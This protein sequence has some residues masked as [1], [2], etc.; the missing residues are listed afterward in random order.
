MVRILRIRFLFFLLFLGL[1]S[2]ERLID[3]IVSCYAIYKAPRVQGWRMVIT[4]L[5]YDEEISLKSFCY[6]PPLDY[7]IVEGVHPTIITSRIALSATDI[8]YRFFTFANKS[9]LINTIDNVSQARFARF[10]FFTAIRGAFRDCERNVSQRR[11]F[12]LRVR[13]TISP[14]CVSIVIGETKWGRSRAAWPLLRGRNERGGLFLDSRR[15]AVR[16]EIASN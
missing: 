7:I 12:F 9:S 4:R 6:D 1:C 10:S 8:D 14:T 2:S 5:Y 11:K 13:A 3:R 16:S 15:R